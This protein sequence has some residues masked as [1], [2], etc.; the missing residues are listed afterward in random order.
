[1]CKKILSLLIIL[2]VSFSTSYTAIA[3]PEDKKI[4]ENKVKYQELNNKIG[5]LN[6]Q[7]A[8]LNGEVEELNSKLEENKKDI[9]STEEQINETEKH[10]EQNKKEVEEGQEVLGKRLRGIYKN[11]LSS[12]YLAVLL[13]SKNLSDLLN[14]MTAINKIVSL[15]N[16]MINELNEKQ[17]ALNKNIDE[18]NTK[19]KELVSLKKS[20]EDSI[21][22]I[23]TKKA[24]GQKYL[25]DLNKEKEQVADI[26]EKN[27][28]ELIS[29]SVNTINTSSNVDDLKK[30]IAT[31]KEVLPQLDMSS[32]MS[33]AKDAIS[34]GNSKIQDLQTTAPTVSYDNNT[35]NRGETGFKKTMTVEATAYSGHSTTAT[36]LK[37]VRNPN[38]LSSIAVDPRVIP[39][40]S[41]V[42]IPGYGYA[43]ASDT[44]GAIK[45]NIIDLYMNSSQECRQWGRRNVTL[46]IVAYPNEW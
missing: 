42:Y 35:V 8:T 27:E 9:H 24:E 4:D 2:T 12:N 6:S 30:A 38:G 41:K 33:K 13:S 15:D 46:H 17:E 25:S 36:G 7:I 40:G 39:L 28:E 44:G 43:I 31:L 10:L 32:V 5:T 34:K 21:K 16:E 26:I 22:E 3:A 1:M 20:T 14:K 29:Y 11:E 45:G 23:D 19:Q 18:L 37:P